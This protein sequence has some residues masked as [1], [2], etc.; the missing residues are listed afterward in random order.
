M[1]MALCQVLGATGL[2]R[3]SPL[4]AVS[5]DVGPQCI[6]VGKVRSDI[7]EPFQLAM[8][9][10]PQLVLVIGARITLRTHRVFLGGV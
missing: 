1:G 6:A 4:V 9:I 2:Y 5:H 8:K 3:L 10:P 7:P